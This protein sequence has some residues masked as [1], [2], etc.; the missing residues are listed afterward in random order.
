MKDKKRPA[1]ETYNLTKLK[2]LSDDAQ[3]T[4][5]KQTRELEPHEDWKPEKAKRFR[6]AEQERIKEIRIRFII[7]Q[8]WDRMKLE[9]GFGRKHAIVYSFGRD[10][11]EPNHKMPHG[12]MF[13][14]CSDAWLKG[15][16]KRVYLHCS[17]KNLKP[18]IE[19]WSSGPEAPGTYGFNIVVHWT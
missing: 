9:A 4:R 13:E 8:I 6:Q 3:T 12:H 16:A 18:T 2:L 19:R 17:D 1:G 14:I 15:T 11:F 7:D 5:R 10:E